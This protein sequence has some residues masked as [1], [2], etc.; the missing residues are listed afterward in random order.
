MANSTDNM[1]HFMTHNVSIMCQMRHRNAVCLK[2]VVTHVK[3]VRHE[4]PVVTFITPENAI[5]YV[6]N[7]TPENT[8]GYVTNPTP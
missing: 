8:T 2:H 1:K 3:D 7:P 4:K 5:G 6:T